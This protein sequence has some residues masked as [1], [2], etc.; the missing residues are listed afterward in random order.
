[1]TRRRGGKLPLRRQRA[2][3]QFHALGGEALRKRSVG[4][5]AHHVPVLLEGGDFRVDLGERA[6]Q[7]NRVLRSTA[8]L[9][10]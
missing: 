2:V 10:A 4:G 9:I 8:R 5:G 7:K 6:A 1:M 3:A